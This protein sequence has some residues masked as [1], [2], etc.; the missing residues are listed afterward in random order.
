MLVFDER[1]TI[2]G[3][4]M[5]SLF[6][7]RA[8]DTVSIFN[9]ASCIFISGVVEILQAGF[10]RKWPLGSLPRTG[11]ACKQKTAAAFHS[12]AELKAKNG[13][14]VGKSPRRPNTD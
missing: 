9:K 2:K 7:Y 4:I 8:T 1:T 12:R 13:G 5:L 6:F 10:A 3:L 14:Q 11:A